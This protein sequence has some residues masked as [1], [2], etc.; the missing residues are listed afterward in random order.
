AVVIGVLLIV[1][2]LAAAAAAS[3]G[4]AGIP[5]SRLPAALGLMQ[6]DPSAV[7]RDQPVLWSTPLPRVVVAI[8]IGALLAAGATVMQGLFRNPLAD[9]ALA[10]IS[11]GFGLSPAPAIFVG[12]RA[13]P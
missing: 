3:V 13:H 2:A 6:G 10:G 5:L 8:I 12:H 9:P 7:A 4:A 11:P 1:L